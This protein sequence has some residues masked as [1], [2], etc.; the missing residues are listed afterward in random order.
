MSIFL[1]FCNGVTNILSKQSLLV[2]LPENGCYI[3]AFFCFFSFVSWFTYYAV[4]PY[5]VRYSARVNSEE[6]DVLARLKWGHHFCS[7]V[8]AAIVALMS[9]YYLATGV[10]SDSV[11]ERVWGHDSRIGFLVS[12]SLG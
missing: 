1:P 7:T 6:F 12:I 2:H 9:T 4:A 10:V 5:L 8:H 11:E 3:L